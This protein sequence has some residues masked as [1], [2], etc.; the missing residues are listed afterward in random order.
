MKYLTQKEIEQLNNDKGL[1]C[2][3]QSKD[4]ASVMIKPSFLFSNIQSFNK[5]TNKARGL[6][7]DSE[8]GEVVCR[9]F[10][11]FFYHDGVKNKDG[12]YLFMNEV[13][14]KV[15]AYRKENGFLGMIGYSERLNEL[16]F[17]SK[18][19]LTN[20]FA[21]NVK[22]IFFDTTT[23]EEREYIKNSLRI[24]KGTLVFEVI[25]AEGDLHL[26][27][28][29][30][31]QLV[32][33]GFVRNGFDFYEY[34]YKLTQEV[35]GCLS[36]I[37]IKERIISRNSF[38]DAI[39]VLGHI[40]KGQRI[41]GWV[42]NDENGNYL[43]VKTSFFV[44]FRKIRGVV[45]FVHTDK[46]WRGINCPDKSDMVAFT[47]LIKSSIE[48]IKNDNR[49]GMK[50]EEKELI[51]EYLELYIDNREYIEAA[52][53]REKGVFAFV[54]TIKAFESLKPFTL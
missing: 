45:Q 11:K 18:H 41:E 33:I 51:I 23:E 21:K 13:R 29:D 52:Y 48:R 14:G 50:D 2:R 43:K 7:F 31:D 49:S 39:N 38:E 27:D 32:I 44:I 8:T 3:T 22:R 15:T 16:V 25:D 24:Y 12:G 19:S 36:Q 4:F 34:D 40:G 54:E 53:A 5:L 26:V 10:D 1:S 6:I 17:A 35:F 46:A 42:V 20:E 47:K 37:K 30:K 28:Y 9:G